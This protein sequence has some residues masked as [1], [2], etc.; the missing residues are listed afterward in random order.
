MNKNLNK[1]EKLTVYKHNDMIKSIFKMTLIEKRILS[2]TI[3]KTNPKRKFDE[4]KVL[5]VDID[6]YSSIYEVNAE[7]AYKEIKNGVKKLLGQYMI[8]SDKSS[9]KAS[10]QVMIPWIYKA[11]F[12][13]EKLTFGIRFH[14]D[15]ALYLHNLALKNL[16]FS[17][18]S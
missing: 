4:E 15:V 10:A 3:A 12:D 6:E 14:K 16:S 11:P 5:N 13:D 8:I 17:K 18:Y 7:T 1:T 9:E 2:L